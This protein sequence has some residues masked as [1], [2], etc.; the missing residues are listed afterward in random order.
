MSVDVIIINYRS[1]DALKGCLAG[2]R[3]WEPEYLDQVVV[4]DNAGAEAP[5]DLPVD[6]PGF[7][8][9]ANEKNVG[10]AKA[11]NLAL[12]QTSAPYICLL[13]PDAIVSGPVWSGLCGWFGAHADAGVVGPRILNSDCSL[14]GS[15]RAFPTLATSFFGRTSFLSRLWPDNPLTRR[16]V[17]ARESLAGP[18]DV[19]WV[20]GACMVVRRSALEKVG[21]LDER[22]FLYW[23]DCDWCTRFRKAG[24]GVTYHPAIGP[25]VHHGGLSSRSAR[26]LS[27][28]HFHRSAV[29]LYWK[30]DRSPARLGSFLAFMGA[31][32][33]YGLLS[34]R[35]VLR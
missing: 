5:A 25:V 21:L 6:L 17:L 34:L 14:Q 12:S 22:F 32:V 4:V 13:N 2:L 28:F 23:E 10:F 15:A 29:L 20:S 19:D 31:A 7:T 27:L 9:L 24:W 30:Y 8:W 11:A 26:L 18:L 33:R 35:V 16:N 3:K 1:N